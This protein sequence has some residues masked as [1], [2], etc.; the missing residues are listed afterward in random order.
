MKY[1]NIRVIPV[2]NEYHLEY[3]K[4][5]EKMLEEANIRV[6][7]DDCNEKLTYKM[8]ES[9]TKKVPYTIIIGDKETDANTVTVRLHVTTE[10]ITLDKDEFL[11][12]IKEIIQNKNIKYDL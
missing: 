7:L 2:N 3:A 4:E 5:I 1:N 12:K 9:Q 10:N 6:K 11:S 8:R